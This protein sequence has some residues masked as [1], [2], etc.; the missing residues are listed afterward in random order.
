[1][2]KG[3]RDWFEVF[4]A[5]THSS[6]TGIRKTYTVD[7]LDKI[8]ERTNFQAAPKGVPLV[9]GHVKTNYP[10]YGYA[11]E[12]KRN[13]QALYAK[14]PQ[15]NTEFEK[16]VQKAAKGRSVSIN[17]DFSLNHIAF[18]AVEDPAL[19][20]SPI[21]YS[22]CENFDSEAQTYDFSMDSTTNSLFSIVGFA[23][24]NLRELIIEKFGVDTADKVVKT[25]TIEDLKRN[26]SEN[27]AVQ[28]FSQKTK[29]VSDLFGK[30]KNKDE[31]SQELAAKDKKIAELEAQLSKNSAKSEKDEFSAQLSV[32]EQKI[33]ELESQLKKQEFE[34]EKAEFSAYLEGL[35]NECKLTPA[36]KDEFSKVFDALKGPQEFSSTTADDCINNIKTA[37]NSLPKQFEFGEYAKK[38]NQTMNFAA[39][40]DVAL[41][42]AIANS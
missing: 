18:L 8:I 6:S 26:Y 38:D 41:G 29:E 39:D 13:G 17:P 33:A 42:Q 5:G 37:L 24:Q 19:D 30:D 31:F 3:L 21:E 1:M 11:T 7:D 35:E 40:K 32:K 28:A 15:V 12:L 2:G 25:W 36:Q 23:L 22:K 14:C 16:F 34:K 4:R 10:T 20:L 9:I 27:D